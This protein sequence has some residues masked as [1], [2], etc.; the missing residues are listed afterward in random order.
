M[1]N[2]T[3]KRVANILTTNG[4]EPNLTVSKE[5]DARFWFRPPQ[6]TTAERDIMTAAWGAADAG[7]EWFNTTTN[8]GEAWDGTQ[9]VIRY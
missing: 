5:G 8:Q 4:Q 2:G 3:V 9:I 6:M 1:D 7:K